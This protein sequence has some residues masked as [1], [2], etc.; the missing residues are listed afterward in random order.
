MKNIV[1]VSFGLLALTAGVHLQT[2]QVINPLGGGEPRNTM[3][4]IHGL[5]GNGAAFAPYFSNPYTTP[6]GFNT[7]V[8]LP[9]AAVRPV[10]VSM[11]TKMTSWFDIYDWNFIST[12]YSMEDIIQSEA[13]LRNLIEAE[14]KR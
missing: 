12:S 14:V 2:F 13:W 5:S 3:I 9:T 4:F 11:G 1:A 10:T 7:R 6:V 8:I